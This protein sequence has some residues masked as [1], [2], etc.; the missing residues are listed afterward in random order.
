MQSKVI[1]ICSECGQRAVQP[2]AGSVDDSMY[3]VQHPQA[4]IHS[5]KVN[6]AALM[7]AVK[8]EA[9]TAAARENG[10][11]GGRPRKAKEAQS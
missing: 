10:K 6:A 7:G 4:L 8:S 9:K 1:Y 11:K 5:I 3:C 2:E